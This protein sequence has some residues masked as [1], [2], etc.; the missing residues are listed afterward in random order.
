MSNPSAGTVEVKKVGFV[1]RICSGAVSRTSDGEKALLTITRVALSPLTLPAGVLVLACKASIRKLGTMKGSIAQRSIK[2]KE[3][4]F[5]TA[6]AHALTNYEKYIGTVRLS[7]D[8]RQSCMK[9]FS[10]ATVALRTEV[11][12]RFSEQPAP[13]RKELK[14]FATRLSTIAISGKRLVQIAET[15]EGVSHDVESLLERRRVPPAQVQDKLANYVPAQM[16]EVSQKLVAIQ[17]DHLITADESSEIMELIRQKRKTILAD[18]EKE[19]PVP[20][21]TKPGFKMPN[22]AASSAPAANQSG[23]TPPPPASI[24]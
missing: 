14:E 16:E 8:G 20:V 15:F 6:L 4:K 24:P 1:K 2:K 19:F 5:D 18:L 12:S 13:T 17:Q 11:Q 22:S 3:K 21:I 7:P 23:P 9:F 10:D